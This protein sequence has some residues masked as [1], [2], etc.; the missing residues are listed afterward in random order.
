MELLVKELPDHRQVGDVDTDVQ[1]TS[2]MKAILFRTLD[3]V[4][5]A[6]IA[7][8]QE[9]VEPE[10]LVPVVPA[11]VGVVAIKMLDVVI[12]Q[13]YGPF[14]MVEIVYHIVISLHLLNGTIQVIELLISLNLVIICV[15]RKVLH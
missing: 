2:K 9:V 12:P 3:P 7:Q 13:I 10:V 15:L 6:S 11:A 1:Y 4:H 5:A 14:K 8:V